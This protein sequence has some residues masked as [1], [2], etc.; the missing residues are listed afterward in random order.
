M[1][2]YTFRKST[3]EDVQKIRAM[4]RDGKS[5]MDI[6]RFFNIDHTTVMYW[7]GRTKRKPKDFDEIKNIDKQRRII[8]DKDISEGKSY[9][10]YVEDNL[11]KKTEVDN[12]KETKVREKTATEEDMLENNRKYK[13]RLYVFKRDNVNL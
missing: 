13:E 1:S 4:Y 5:T 10:E 8:N 12:K 6:G 2:H 9:K 11:R 3:S 7:L